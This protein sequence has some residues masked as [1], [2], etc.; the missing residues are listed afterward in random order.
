MNASGLT[1]CSID[2]CGVIGKKVC[3]DP[4]MCIMSTRTCRQRVVWL[5]LVDW[6]LHIFISPV[7][8]YVSNTI[9]F[10]P[11]APGVTNTTRR[12]LLLLARISRDSKLQ[13]ETTSSSQRRHEQNET[14]LKTG[15]KSHH[16]I[17]MNV[18][19]F[20]WLGA[21]EYSISWCR[22]TAHERAQRHDGTGGSTV[23]YDDDDDDSEHSTIRW[24][25]WHMQCASSFNIFSS[26]R[27]G[28]SKR[29]D[30]LD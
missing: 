30:I 20:P 16:L 24:W 15:H 26:S 28:L 17:P 5:L 29:V 7:S 3:R 2:T 21:Q 14:Y 22:S 4:N 1:L 6:S 11:D 27:S 12:F 13:N 9:S 10:W 23:S 18:P 25:S 8:V 19:F